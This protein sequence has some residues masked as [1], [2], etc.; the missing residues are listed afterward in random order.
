M[1]LLAGV[2]DPDIERVK[3]L[4]DDHSFPAEQAII[5]SAFARAE[6][7]IPEWAKAIKLLAAEQEE[8]FGFGAAACAGFFSGYLTLFPDAKIISVKSDLVQ[9]IADTDIEGFDK[10][11][12]AR[13]IFGGQSSINAVLNPVPHAI[14]DMSQNPTDDEIRA[15]VGELER[16]A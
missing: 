3:E 15:L 2:Y 6:L 7:T 4:L 8:P 12:V 5:D 14:V 16:A 10:V 9:A 1:I 11:D 13:S